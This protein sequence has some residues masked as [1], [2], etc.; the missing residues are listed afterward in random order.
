MSI[1]TTENKIA[2][3]KVDITTMIRYEKLSDLYDTQK[4]K[5]A[6]A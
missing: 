3:Q 1:T 6:T 4:V 5:M 2:Y